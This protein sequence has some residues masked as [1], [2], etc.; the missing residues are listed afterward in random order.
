MSLL[1]L[2]EILGLFIITL[3]PNDSY[4]LRSSEN[5]W[6]PINLQLSKKKILNFLPLL[7]K[8]HQTL[9]IS[10]KKMTLIGDVFLE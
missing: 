8:L 3:T 4:S 10:N 6:Q 2:S 9:N 7:W 1:V 5:L